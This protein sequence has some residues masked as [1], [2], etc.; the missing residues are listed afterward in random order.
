MILWTFFQTSDDISR[1]KKMLFA[2][3]CIVFPACTSTCN[4]LSRY[5]LLGDILVIRRFFIHNFRFWQRPYGA[6]SQWKHKFKEFKYSVDLCLDGDE[7][8]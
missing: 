3:I 4:L 1:Y 7:L 8:S 2:P 6:S 5:V